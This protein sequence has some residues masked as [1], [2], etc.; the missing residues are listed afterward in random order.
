MRI[1]TFFD[2]V[3]NLDLQAIQNKLMFEY[4]WTAEKTQAV[5]NHYKLF[6][7]LKSIYPAA[8]LVPTQEID[9]VWHAHMEVNLLKYI[10]DCDYLFGYLLN[11]CSAVDNEI[12]QEI[13]Q[14]HKQAFNTTKALFENIFGVGVLENTS[15]HV[16]AC[17]DLPLNTNPAACADLP[18]IPIGN[19]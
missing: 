11:H 9:A 16:A 19:W 8:G 2:K 17:A 3:N 5:I 13:H 4:E 12:N 6:L 7:Y 18:I 15:I 1:I 10:Q 14:I